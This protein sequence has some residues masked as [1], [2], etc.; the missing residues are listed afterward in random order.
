MRKFT[1]YALKVLRYLKAHVYQIKRPFEI[2]MCVNEGPARL[3]APVRLSVVHATS[4]YFFFFCSV[5]VGFFQKIRVN[6]FSL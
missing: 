4:M 5:F 3:R 1:S 6:I 2:V